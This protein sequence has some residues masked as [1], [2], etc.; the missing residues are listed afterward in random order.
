[1]H[2]VSYGSQ[3]VGF[4]YATLCKLNI[5]DKYF[6]TSITLPTLWMKKINSGPSD[7][8]ASSQSR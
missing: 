1:M 7:L 2:S 4:V 3:N 6:M 8:P 5:K